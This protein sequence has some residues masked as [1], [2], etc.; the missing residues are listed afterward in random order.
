MDTTSLSMLEQL[1]QPA[2]QQAWRRFVQLYTPLLYHWA[3]S[4]GCQSQDA[5]DLVQDVFV[6]L[7]R[8]LPEF[9]YDPQKSFRGWLRTI[10]LNKWRDRCRHDALCPNA[11]NDDALAAVPDSDDTAAFEEAEYRRHVV[12]RALQLMQTDFQPTTWKACWEHVVAGR[13]AAE[14]AAELGITVNAVYLAKSR[15]LSRLRQEIGALLS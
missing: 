14:V 15:V 1:R 5:A 2:D 11:G 13:P 6:T 4:L 9:A 12:R 3:R 10:T 8:K 7:F